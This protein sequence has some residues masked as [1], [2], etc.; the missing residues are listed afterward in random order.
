MSRIK[1]CIKDERCYIKNLEKYKNMKKM[2]V[3]EIVKC[4]LYSKTEYFPR[5]CEDLTSIK[6]VNVHNHISKLIRLV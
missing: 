1:K 3:G 6:R 2:E 5:L 4:I